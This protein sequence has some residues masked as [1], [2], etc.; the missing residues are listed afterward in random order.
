[1]TE[2][3]VVVI[4]EQDHVN[5]FGLVDDIHDFIADLMTDVQQGH[6]AMISMICCKRL[7][8]GY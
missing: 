1:M 7:G 2:L 4:S 3:S 5:G 8:V 6:D